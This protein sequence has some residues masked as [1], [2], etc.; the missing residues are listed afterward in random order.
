MMLK[1]IPS[2]PAPQEAA[3][4]IPI[5]TNN[6]RLPGKN[7]RILGDKPLLNH[8]FDTLATTSVFSHVFVDSSDDLI[9]DIARWYGFLPIKRPPHLNSPETS[10]HDLLEFEMATI[11]QPIIAQ[12]FVT[13]PFLKASTISSAVELLRNSPEAT[14]ILP[15]YEIFNR[16]WFGGKPVAH[17]PAQLIG[18]QYA[19]PV[20][21][22]TGF[23]VFRR[24]AFLQEHARVTA[25]HKPLTTTT[26]EAID[27]DQEH[28]FLYAEAIYA[29]Q[30]QAK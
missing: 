22:E 14:S 6:Q 3:A 4:V 24:E 20:F 30:K 7:T 19:R 26:L 12:L 23:Y 13:L 10:G 9:L 2:N 16:F 1:I 21:G 18:T 27:I 15:V 17:N 28:D 5:K 25:H 8:L 29:W 11:Q